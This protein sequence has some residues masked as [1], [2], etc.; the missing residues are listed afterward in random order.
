MLR[1]P[2]ATHRPVQL[3]AAIAAGDADG[4]A[5][6]LSQGLQDFAAQIPHGQHLL[7]A[8]LVVDAEALGSDTL[9]EFA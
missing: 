1:A 2:H 3:L 8:R 6:V 5:I 7:I 4:V 9:G